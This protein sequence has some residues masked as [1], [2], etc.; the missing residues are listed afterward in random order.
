MQSLY[1]VFIIESCIKYAKNTQVTYIVKDSTGVMLGQLI[2]RLDRK[3]KN[4]NS[5]LSHL[6]QLLKQ[7]EENKSVAIKK[8]LYYGNNIL[9]G[10]QS[11]RQKAQLFAL[12]LGDFL[13]TKFDCE[14]QVQVHHIT[15]DLMLN[16]HI[17]K[18]SERCNLPNTKSVIVKS[19][20]NKIVH[21]L[22]SRGLCN[23]EGVPCHQKAWIALAD[24]EI[25]QKAN[26]VLLNAVSSYSAVENFK[27]ILSRALY[28]CHSS[29]AKTLAAKHRTST[30][31]LI[32]QRGRLL[33]TTLKD[34]CHRVIAS[35]V[36]LD[37]QKVISC[38]KTN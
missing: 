38:L 3:T 1:E 2:N 28:I 12:E 24:V 14:V 19:H 22:F 25:V 32:K 7:K 23:G 6:K 37:Q 5:L 10:V 13:R 18:M 17:L 15:E 27:E 20:V 36:L 33:Q 35:A 9:L 16:N 26:S 4:R 21:Q 8:H 11:N 34:A 30:K 31:A 29:A